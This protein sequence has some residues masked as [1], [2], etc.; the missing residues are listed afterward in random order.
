MVNNKTRTTIGKVLIDMSLKRGRLAA[1]E[2][3]E[4]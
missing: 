2:A 3:K 1:S 4:K